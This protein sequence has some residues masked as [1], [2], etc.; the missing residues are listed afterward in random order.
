MEVNVRIDTNEY[1]KQVNKIMDNMIYM[2]AFDKNTRDIIKEA[3][4]INEPMP[5]VRSDGV[6][7]ETILWLVR[8]SKYN[9]KIIT[10]CISIIID[11][12][13]SHIK[14]F[15]EELRDLGYNRLA[16][17]IVSIGFGTIYYN[18]VMYAMKILIDKGININYVYNQ[19]IGIA[20]QVLD[21]IIS[22]QV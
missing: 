2:F 9:D 18:N 15:I 7:I 16:I 8:M 10:Q 19:S 11:R 14:A 20:R 1:W 6:P 4:V 13:Y 22:N 5:I 12:N 3:N 21:D 17:M